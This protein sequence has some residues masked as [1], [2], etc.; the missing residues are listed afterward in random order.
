MRFSTD[1]ILHMKELWNIPLN[2]YRINKDI[3]KNTH[4][5]KTNNFHVPFE[6]KNENK[7]YEQQKKSNIKNQNTKYVCIYVRLDCLK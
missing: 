6:S 4:H 2:R 7:I 5:Y 3:Q 1:N